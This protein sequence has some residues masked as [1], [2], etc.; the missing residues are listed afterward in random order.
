MNVLGLIVFCVAV[1]ISLSY[2]GDKGKPLADIF[3]ALDHVINL[4]V[5]LLMW[6]API[7]IA[8]LIA[9]KIMEIHDLAKTLESLSLYMATVIAGLILHLFGTISLIYFIASRENP[10]KFLRGLLQAA[11]TALGTAS[12]AATLPV[13][14]RCLEANGVDAAYTKV[15]TPV[16]TDLDKI[17]SVCTP[18]WCNDQHGW[19]SSL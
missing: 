17:F 11:M 18:R 5:G 12:S 14:F 8:S 15:R 16:A 4:L 2:L 13:T 10:Y 1:G 9:A 7:G 19:Y 6:Y 3:I